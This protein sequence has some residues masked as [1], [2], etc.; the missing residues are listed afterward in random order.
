MALGQLGREDAEE[1]FFDA[2]GYG[3]SRACGWRKDGS[4]SELSGY[5]SHDPILMRF[6][7]IDTPVIFTQP[8]GR[9][10]QNIVPVG[11]HL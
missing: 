11:L 7:D 8:D 3:P 10:Q 6:I 9:S 1:G 2:I 4:A 5:N